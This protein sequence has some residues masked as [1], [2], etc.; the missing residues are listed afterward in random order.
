MLAEFAKCWPVSDRFQKKLESHTGPPIL[1]VMEM[2]IKYN[3]GEIIKI[4]LWWGLYKKVG[5]RVFGEAR[6]M[7]RWGP[8]LTRN[9]EIKKSRRLEIWNC[10]M[11]SSDDRDDRNLRMHKKSKQALVTNGH[12]VRKQEEGIN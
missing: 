11:E 10:E 12:W 9:S 7:E 3:H 5:S 4:D 6:M 2:K 8:S 1:V